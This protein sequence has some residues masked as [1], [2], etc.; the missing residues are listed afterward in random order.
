MERNDEAIA[1]SSR[2]KTAWELMWE[3]GGPGLWAPDYR[4]QYDLKV[5]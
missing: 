5:P 4:E 2:K 1:D 3:N